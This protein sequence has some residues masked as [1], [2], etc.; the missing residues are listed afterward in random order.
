MAASK[1]YYSQVR[2]AFGNRD[3]WWAFLF[4]LPNLVVFSVFTLFPILFA[5]VLS[6]YQWNVIEPPTFVGLDN[7]IHFLKDDK[8]ITSLQLNI[9]LIV[10][11]VPTAVVISFFMAILINRK[12]AGIHLIR[13]MFYFPII[14]SLVSSAFIW[15][16][17]YSK[18]FGVL[19]YGLEWLG[20]P[21]VDWLGDDN[22][23]LLA[24]AI[25]I[26]WKHIPPTLIIY[27]A[28]LQSVPK[29]LYEAASLDGAGAWKKMIHI[30]WP[31]VSNATLLLFILNMIW[32]F[33]GSFDAIAVLT[34][35][36]PYGSTEIIIY[37]L[38][39]KAFMELNMG[40]ASALGIVLFVISLFITWLQFSLKKR[41]DS[42]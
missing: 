1:G 29:H 38:Y 31:M 21:P 37:Y 19:N 39:E 16:W 8:A 24:V 28:A 9:L 11:S 10:Y 3:N 14:I 20:I 4:H 12:L 41:G 6:F 17:I 7:Y 40:Y 33:F 13:T 34:G 25:V 18:N 22:V 32:T 2:R 23:A 35:G 27:L 15:K 30:T 5:I 26:I 36:G 42:K